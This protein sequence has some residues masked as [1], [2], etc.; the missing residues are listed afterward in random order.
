VN[1]RTTNYANFPRQIPELVIRAR[2]RNV[3]RAQ[4]LCLA[5]IGEIRIMVFPTNRDAAAGEIPA[6]PHRNIRIRQ[7]PQ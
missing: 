7:Q 3:S 4:I 2:I 6:D 5:L 1:I